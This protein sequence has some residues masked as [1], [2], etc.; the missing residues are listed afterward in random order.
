MKKILLYATVRMNLEDITMISQT[1]KNK[2]CITSYVQ[3]TNVELIKAVAG[4]R[5][6]VGLSIDQYKFSVLPH[7]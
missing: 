5:G 4:V 6:K 2:C 1:K 7:E 3:S